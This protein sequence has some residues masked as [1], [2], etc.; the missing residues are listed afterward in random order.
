MWTTNTYRLSDGQWVG[1]EGPELLPQTITIEQLSG[2]WLITNAEFFDPP[3]FCRLFSMII[4][5][6][7][8]WIIIYPWVT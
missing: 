3:A 4:Q 5:Q 8:C 7:I 6:V 1:G 2:S